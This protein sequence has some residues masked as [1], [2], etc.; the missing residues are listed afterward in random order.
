MLRF[1]VTSKVRRRLLVLLWG[2]KKR[3]SVRE[4]AALCDVSFASAHAELKGME[5]LQLVHVRR[6]G[7]RDVYSANPQHPE[8]GLLTSLVQTES[9]ARAVASDGD[10]E[11]KQKLVGLGAPL[12]GV[13]PMSVAPDKLH[14]VL[15]D[16]VD[17]ARR[18]PVVARSLPL[19]VWKQRDRLDVKSIWA[20]QSGPEEKH[21]LAF[22]L[23]LA[24]ELGND[25]RLT[26][27]AEGLRDHRLTQL[28]PFFRSSASGATRDFAL[29]KKWGF[30]MNADLES[31]RALFDKFVTT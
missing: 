18:D 9:R 8:A 24:S 10:D 20:L 6:D 31:F 5:R 27:M 17:L 28:K 16:G 14:Q 23:D 19:C 7:N 21:A 4:V 29:A 15:A 11:L 2:E 30:M 22:F 13:K 26:G 12:R 1:L 25:R 3:G